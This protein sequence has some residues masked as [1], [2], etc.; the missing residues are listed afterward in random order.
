MAT[1]RITLHPRHSIITTPAKVAFGFTRQLGGGMRHRG[2]DIE[3]YFS[4]WVGNDAVF[5]LTIFDADDGQWL[6]VDGVDVP[7][8]A[9][10]STFVARPLVR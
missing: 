9:G 1:L 3:M 7:L 6:Y 5:E 2:G 4:G 10:W 8:S